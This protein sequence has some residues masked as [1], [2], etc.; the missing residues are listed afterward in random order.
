VSMVDADPLAGHR[1]VFVGGLHRSGT[2]P[3][4]RWISR[5]PAVSGF[6]DTG[7]WEDEGQHLQTV[8]PVSGQHGGP[9]RFAFHEAAHLTEHS[10]LSTPANRTK[11]AKEW[12]VHWDL[13]RPV[14]VEKS[15]GNLVRMRFLHALFPDASFVMIVRH[16][17]ATAFAT[18]KWLRRTLS[19]L[20]RHWVIAHERFATDAERVPRVMLIRYEELVAEPQAVLDSIFNRLGLPPLTQRWEVQTGLNAGYLERWEARGNPYRAARRAIVGARFESRVARFGYSLRRP[21]DL[22]EPDS[23]LRRYLIGPTASPT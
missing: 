10:P 23:A 7:V 2:T 22:T 15:P 19:S 13:S 1:L 21:D 6:H 4:V 20:I 17:I 14:L 12:A 11:L 5:H 16:P 18:Q 9:G 3:L 8:Y